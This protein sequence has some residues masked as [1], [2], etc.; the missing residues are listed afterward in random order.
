MLYSNNPE[1]QKRYFEANRITHVFIWRESKTKWQVFTG[2]DKMCGI[3]K[4]T[5]KKLKD[6]KVLADQYVKAG[7]KFYKGNY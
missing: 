5:F 4:G 2:N 3:P 1:L 7:L 6:A